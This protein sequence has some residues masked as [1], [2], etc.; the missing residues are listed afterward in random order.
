MKT[1]LNRKRLS[2]T[3]TSILNGNRNVLLP[4]HPLSLHTV[5]S[6]NCSERNVC[7][8]NREAHNLLR[9]WIYTT[10]P[11]SSPFCIICIESVNGMSMLLNT[12]LA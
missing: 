2:K 12:W 10:L 1:T 5:K 6:L 11:I 4:R 3:N 8:Y 9:G 7:I